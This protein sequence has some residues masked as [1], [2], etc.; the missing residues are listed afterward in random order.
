MASDEDQRRRDG[1]DGGDDEDVDAQMRLQAA[2]AGLKRQADELLR[3]EQHEKAL[4][5]YRELL[6]H[7]TRSHVKVSVSVFYAL[8][9]SSCGADVTLP[10]C[11]IA[12]ADAPAGSGRVVP[13]EH[14]GGAQ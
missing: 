2:T 3:D 8:G 14:L 11:V 13:N 7:L 4:R 12:S 1:A 6:M 5:L 9:F 10:L